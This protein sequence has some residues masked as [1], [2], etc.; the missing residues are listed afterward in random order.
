MQVPKPST[1][2]QFVFGTGPWNRS[3]PDA[4]DPCDEVVRAQLAAI[5][6]SPGFIRSARLSRL[7]EF[8]VT[9]ALNGRTELLKESVIG[10]EA[11]G[12]PPSYS[13]RE[14]PGVRI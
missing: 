8:I 14:D 4:A 12:K 6:A 2:V 9:A 3:R 5:L 13:P 11:F 10:V 1:T 7:L